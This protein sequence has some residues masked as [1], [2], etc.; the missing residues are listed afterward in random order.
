MLGSIAMARAAVASGTGTIVATPHV[1]AEYDFDLAEVGRRVGEVN[2]ALA[3]KQ[4]PLAVVSGGEVAMGRLAEMSDEAIAT[5]RLGAGSGLLVES[6][7]SSAP[8][9]MEELL[10]GLQVRGYTPVLAHPERCP[11]FQQE[12]DR[13]EAIVARNILCSVNT[14]SMAGAFGTTARRFVLWML[15]KGLVHDVAS[16]AHD[17]IRRP[18]ALAVGFEH[19]EAD[20]PGIADQRT[21]Y[22]RDAPAAIL[23]G[24]PLPPRPEPPSQKRRGFRRL[25][26]RG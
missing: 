14:G 9:L 22:T 4:I 20:L 15:S 6:P 11:L 19:A 1:N 16:D 3:R 13:L 5:V 25:I 2:V 26:G 7:Y 8:M 10:F 18:P 24:R 17:H 21:W 12:P 23:A